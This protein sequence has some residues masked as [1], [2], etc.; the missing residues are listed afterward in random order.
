M[1]LDVWNKDKEKLF[2]HPDYLTAKVGGQEI[3]NTFLYH[4]P[5]GYQTIFRD[6]E[7]NDHEEGF[8]VW[9]VPKDWQKM[10]V[11]FKEFEL[12]GGKR[13]KLTVTKKDLKDPVAPS[14]T[15]E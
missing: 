4:S 10:A 3:K 7:G 2:F 15:A 9:E 6:I 1:F 11:T 5:E 12:L 13:L 8:I 14:K